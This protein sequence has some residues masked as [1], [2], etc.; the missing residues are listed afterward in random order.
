MLT[1]I[2]FKKGA[3]EVL[4]KRG[5]KG[6]NTEIKGRNKEDIQLELK[7]LQDDTKISR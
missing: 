3:D 7:H 5:D 6:N 4:L 1:N 2:N